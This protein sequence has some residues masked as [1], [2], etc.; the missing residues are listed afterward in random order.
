MEIDLLTKFNRGLILSLVDKNVYEALQMY[1]QYTSYLHSNDTNPEVKNELQKVRNE[2]LKKLLDFVSDEK[3]KDKTTDLISAYQELIVAYPNDSNFYKNAASCFKSLKQ[4]DIELE[5]LKKA[6]SICPDNISI[7]KKLAESYK[8]NGNINEAIKCMDYAVKKEPFNSADYF[9]LGMLYDLAYS[10]T[11]NENDLKSAIINIEIARKMN[12]NEKL[13]LKSLLILYT[14]AHDEEKLK[15]AWEKYLKYPDLDYD[16][17]FDYSAYLIRHGDLKKGFEMYETRFYS[18]KHKGH[19]DIKKGQRYDGKKDLQGKTVLIQSE[20]GFGD[21]IFFSRFF[22]EFKNKTGKIIARVPKNIAPVI[23][24]SF[25]F[26]EVVEIESSNPE[27]LKFDYWFSMMSLAHFTGVTKENI[28]NTGKYLIADENKTLQFKK[29]IFNNDKFKIG[30]IHKGKEG[31]MAT[32]NVPVEEFFPLTELENTQVYAL[33]YNEPDKTYE[34]SKIINL[35][36]KIKSFDDT[37]SLIENMD[38]IVTVDN[39]VMNLAGALGKKTFCLFNDV[40]EFRWFDLSGDDVKWY[41]AVKPYVAK[42]QNEWTP[43]MNKIISDIK[44]LK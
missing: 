16:D 13:Y 14:K 40:P 28:P 23:K 25:P 17:K 7:K 18:N 11:N 31:G 24:R 19:P 9:T 30:I 20:Q 33:I 41:K 21:T 8:N 42:K 26:V 12:E 36:D 4:Y 1:R 2:F 29:E 5:L 43:V 27:T 22:S 37:A 32:R 6:E 38:L 10:E 15:L 34:N 35:A 44:G 39:A 3:N